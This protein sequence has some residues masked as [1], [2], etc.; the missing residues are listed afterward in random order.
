MYTIQTPDFIILKHSRGRTLL[1]IF[2]LILFSDN[3]SYIYLY[4]IS[5]RTLRPF[6]SKTEHI[7]PYQ[8]FYQTSFLALKVAVKNDQAVTLRSIEKE[9]RVSA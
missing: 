3:Y 7:S 1:L 6:P 9:N 5:R 8:V 2:L 4:T